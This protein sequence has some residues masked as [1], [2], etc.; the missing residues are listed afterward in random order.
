MLRVNVLGTPSLLWNEEPLTIARRIPRAI[1]YYLAVEGRSVSRGKLQTLFWSDAPD[2]V[3]RARLRDNLTKLRAALPAPN[4]LQT[5]DDTL[6]LAPEKVQVDLLEFKILLEDTGQLPWQ[7]SLEKPLPA[8]MYQSLAAAAKLWRGP[9]F[10]SGL[11][12][13]GSVALDDWLQIKEREIKNNL[14][15]ILDRLIAH[16][17]AAG[18]LER[19]I[20]WAL[21]A[22]QLDKLDESRHIVL[23][24]TCLDLNRRNEAQRHYR[25]IET[26]Y[27]NKLKSELPE[28]IRLLQDQIFNGQSSVRS[29]QPLE[30]PIHSSIQTPFVGQ[31]ELL[32][33]LDKI[34][35]TSSG[36]VIFGEAG[37]GK[38]RLVQEYYQRRK[39]KPRL[40]MGTGHSTDRSLPYYT[41]TNLLRRSIRPEEW[42]RL[43]PAWAVPLTVIL[44]E[45]KETHHELRGRDFSPPEYPR[46]VLLES[47]HQLLCL[48]VKVNPLIVFIDDVHWVDESSLTVLSY[49]LEQSFFDGGHAFLMMTARTEERN[50]WLDKLLL[51]TPSQKLRQ[52]EVPVLGSE[53]V[54]H[55]VHYVLEQSPPQAFVE[56]LTRDA[57]GNPLYVLETLQ[58][59]IQTD[60]GKDI[61]EIMSFPLTPSIHQLTQARLQDLND[62]ALEIISVGALLGADFSLSLMLEIVKEE[63]VDVLE[64]LVELEVARLLQSSQ[65]DEQIRY[66]FVH[67]KIRESILF[68]LSPA[69][70][71][72]LH[73]KIAETLEKYLGTH[74]VS[75][76]ARIAYHYQASGNL[77]KAFDFW[78]QA[79]RHAYSLSSI[80][81]ATDA[82]SNAE[83]LI[84]REPGLSEDRLYQLYASWSDMAFENGNQDMLFHINETLLSLGRERHS[85]LLSGIAYDGLSDAYFASNQFERG[86][87]F[88]K[89]AISYLQRAGNQHELLNAQLHHGVFLYMLGEFNEAREILYDV[90][91]GMPAERDA[92]YSRLNCNLFYQIGI[93]EALTGYPVKALEFLNQAIEPGANPPISSGAML[94]YTAI[95]LA[96]YI[97]GDFKAGYEASHK[98]VDLG[99]KLE[100]QRMLGYAYA[101]SALSAHNLGLLDEAWKYA[102][103]A[104]YIGQRYGHPEI[105]A[106]AYRTF[107]NTY[108]R[109]EDYPSAIEHFQKGIRIAGEHYVALELMTLLGYSM[110][111]IGQVEEGF[112]YLT[113]AYETASQ[114]QLG[115]ISVYARSLLL[116]TRSQHMDSNENI[117]EEIE[118]ALADSKARSINKATAILEAPFVRANRQPADFIKRMNE[119]LQIVSGLSD[120]LFEARLLRDLIIYKKNRDLPRQSEVDRLTAI[121]EELA[122]RAAGMPFGNAW[123]RYYEAMITIGNG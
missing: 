1:L 80:Q 4:L 15:R 119:S 17:T 118:Q 87:D 27:Q 36:V 40:L 26:Y 101:Y 86:L 74:A 12:W 98:A 2:E 107:G 72:L 67:E 100:Y 14:H 82:F 95:G 53:E 39:I 18:N 62:L 3:A 20:D 48:L 65:K 54:A 24:K 34:R 106:L 51:N 70:Q 88:A 16:E 46:T 84:P 105:S 85:D 104:L 115:A 93:V 91:K 99:I 11:S 55:L 110:A 9:D 45:L 19:V 71:R 78:V 83:R 103:W 66:A 49:L 33:Q 56:R 109:L 108:M 92:E 30:W 102:N 57:G 8:A 60:L 122:P 6:M 29:W 76:A 23:L 69:R 22:I 64:A 94:I 42:Q 120:L 25:E 52:V 37:V 123:Q 41:W 63:M 68:S 112:A 90:F 7:I 113:R 97:K 5:I 81:E 73:A 44:P 79:G 13:P 58:A 111:V 59:M 121:L 43:S 114:L 75:Q 32:E 31:E 61:E 89:E 77:L 117:L 10:L 35:S 28:S 47:I 96:H 21:M 38:T 50:L 116:L